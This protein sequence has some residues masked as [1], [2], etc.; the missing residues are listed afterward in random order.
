MGKLGWSV[1][2][3]TH[4][5]G[6]LIDKL[7]IADW[8]KDEA[9]AVLVKTA[10]QSTEME[11]ESWMRMWGWPWPGRRKRREDQDDPNPPAE[12]PPSSTPSSSTATPTTTA[13]PQKQKSHVPK[14]EIDAKCRDCFKW[15][16]FDDYDGMPGRG[17]NKTKER[18]GRDGDEEPEAPPEDPWATAFQRLS[19]AIRWRNYRAIAN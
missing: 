15:E 6:T 17:G 18:D 8:A 9:S 2:V 19:G 11:G 16:F 1:D 4:R 13:P 5:I 7:L 12:D 3:R 14:P 10:R